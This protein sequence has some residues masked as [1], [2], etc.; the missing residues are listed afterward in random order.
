MLDRLYEATWGRMF[1]AGYDRLTEAGEEAGMR[2]ARRDLVAHARG[3][4]VE[5]GAGTGR[6][7][8][9]Y[10]PEVNELVVTE[11][12]PKMADR[13]RAKPE[14]ARASTIVEAGAES[15]PFPD[16]H[17]DTAVATLVLC[18]VP[19]QRAALREIAR[20]LRPGGTLLFIEHVR[21]QDDGLAR[22]QD[23]LEGPWRFVGDGCHCNRDTVA[24]LGESPFD[25][26]RIERG[27]LPKTPP[28]VRPMVTGA[29]VLPA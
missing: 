29:A 27:H 5:I 26:Q 6:N 9:H 13:L 1:A 12:D 4:T 17:F 28:I 23:R 14:A 8:E 7:L 10:P 25:V 15:L 20:V 3:R 2:D 18:T 22:W 21:A 19:D 16:D 11:P 24:M